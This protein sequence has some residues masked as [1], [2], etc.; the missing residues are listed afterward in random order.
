MEKSFA[1]YIRDDYLNEKEQDKANKAIMERKRLIGRISIAI[2]FSVKSAA[3]KGLHS[4]IGYFRDYEAWDEQFTYIGNEEN[5]AYHN[6]TLPLDIDT[7]V[8]LN[9]VNLMIRELGFKDFNVELEK[10]MDYKVKTFKTFLGKEIK[11][12]TP[13]G[14]AGYMIKIRISW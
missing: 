5:D 13:N 4:I 14:Y 6:Y 11:H 12:R 10:K 3:D 1:D 2:K 7:S 9:E 8:F